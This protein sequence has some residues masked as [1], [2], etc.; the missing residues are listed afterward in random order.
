MNE[1][2]QLLE[3]AVQA[4]Q[5]AQKKLLEIDPGQQHQILCIMNICGV[6]N[7]LIKAQAQSLQHT[8]AGEKKKLQTPDM[9]K[10]SSKR[11]K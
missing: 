4:V 7:E 5:R 2:D 6:L 3:D 11:P 1:Q 9:S 8:L 10:L